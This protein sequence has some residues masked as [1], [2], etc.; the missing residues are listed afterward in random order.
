MEEHRL[1]VLDEGYDKELF[2]KLYKNLTPLKKRLASQIDYK[3]FGLSYEDM[4]SWFDIKFIFVFQKHQGFSEQKMQAFLIKAMQT[5]KYR[6]L[7]VAYQERYA[8]NPIELTDINQFR[9]LPEDSDGKLEMLEMVNNF[10][11]NNLSPQAYIVY[12]I[13]LNPPLYIRNCLEINGKKNINN[14]PPSLICEYLDWGVSSNSINLVK[15]LRNEVKSAI[16]KARIK[17]NP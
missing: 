14:I 4:L 10:M 1:K 16:S 2:N 11:K 17:L 15:Q 7:R 6:I 9:Y 8:N 12:L 5:Y 13:D 3:R